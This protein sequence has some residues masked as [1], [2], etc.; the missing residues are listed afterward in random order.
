M[1]QKLGQLSQ[2]LQ[3][4]AAADKEMQDLHNRTESARLELKDIAET[5]EKCQ[6]SEG[7]DSSEIEKTEERLYLIY[8]LQKKHRCTSCEE[9][10]QLQTSME[11]EARRAKEEEA[12]LEQ[13]C[14]RLEASKSALSTAAAEL[15]SA[16]RAAASSFSVAVTAQLQG[17]GMPHGRFQVEQSSCP[18]QKDGADQIT[19]FFSAN[20][21]ISLQLLA[22]V[23]SGGER[24]RLMFIIKHLLAAKQVLPTLIFDEIDTGISGETAKRMVGMLQQISKKQQVLLISHLPQFAAKAEKHFFIYK[25]VV[26]SHTVSKMRALKE[27]ERIEVLAQMLDGQRPSEAALQNARSMRHT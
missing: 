3:E 24:S 5:L 2:L 17:L 26:D 6:I 10:L 25:E 23:A 15:S 4:I 14:S 27:E 21:G 12:A 19:F 20:V 7:G 16:R 9:L 22:K 11:E 8:S 18:F 1:L 13:S